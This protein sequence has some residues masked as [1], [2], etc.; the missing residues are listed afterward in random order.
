MEENGPSAPARRPVDER[1]DTI[2]P[3][4]TLPVQ[5][6]RGPLI[7]LFERHRA[8]HPYGLADLEEP[9]WSRST[10]WQRGEAAVGLIGIPAAPIDVVYAISEAAPEATTRLLAE[11]AADHLPHR[12]VVTGPVGLVEAVS[13]SH[14]ARWAALHRKMVLDGEPP[15]PDRGAQRVRRL[16]RADVE[17]IRRLLASDPG[18]GDFFVDD[19]VDTGCYFGIDDGG[20]LVSMAGVHVLDHHRGVAAVGNVATRPDHRRRGMGRA[21][22]V[23]LV[24]E[25]SGAVPTIGLNVRQSNRAA[26][27]LYESLGF[28]WVM[29]YQE[30]ELVRPAD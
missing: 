3:A 29:D 28:R 14:E 30:A 22:T 24:E 11:L 18:A 15:K 27:S 6:E 19:L 8:V 20:E 13:G 4:M 10:W 16:G 2:G 12:F 1:P 21:V 25:L 23:R 26:I 7:A 5:T 9:Y 17:G